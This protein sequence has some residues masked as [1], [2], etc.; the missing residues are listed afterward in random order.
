MNGWK[1]A[2]PSPP[3]RTT[4]SPYPFAGVRSSL[5]PIRKYRFFS[6]PP[7]RRSFAG[8][9]ATS[10]SGSAGAWAEPARSATGSFFGNTGIGSVRTASGYRS[11]FFSHHC[12]H[13]APLCDS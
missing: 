9:S 5:P 2:E 6:S 8:T 11:L 10:A 1:S 7:M 13:H 3:G 12:R 4:S